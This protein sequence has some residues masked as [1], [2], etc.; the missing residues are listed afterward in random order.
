M[1]KL[2]AFVTI[3]LIVALP[4]MAGKKFDK[5]ETWYQQKVTAQAEQCK[6]E[7]SA[8]RASHEEEAQLTTLSEE[9]LPEAMSANEGKILDVYGNT[10]TAQFQANRLAEAAIRA[11]R[12]F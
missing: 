7:L 11:G 2:L 1:R 8:I 3:F 10:I 4:A 9:S 6:A 12:R 5:G